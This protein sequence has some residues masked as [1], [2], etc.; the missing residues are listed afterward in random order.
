MTN[1]LHEGHIARQFVDGIDLGTIYIF[2][3]IVLEQVAIG[4]D[5]E[6]FTQ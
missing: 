1:N 4:V 3:R 5:A 6:F 2:I